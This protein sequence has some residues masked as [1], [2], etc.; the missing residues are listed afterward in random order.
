MCSK[1]Q[2]GD[3]L[4]HVSVDQVTLDNAEDKGNTLNTLHCI[5]VDVDRLKIMTS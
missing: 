3:A 5:I 2:L 4:F 1:L